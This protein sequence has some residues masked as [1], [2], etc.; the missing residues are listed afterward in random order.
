MIGLADAHLRL[1]AEP[2]ERDAPQGNGNEE[3]NASQ[4][5]DPQYPG[6][7]AALQPIAQNRRGIPDATTLGY[8]LR[9]NQDKIVGGRKINKHRAVAHTGGVRWVMA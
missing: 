8:Y 2:E 5:G 1:L 7:A 6:L 3:K 4:H 9:Q